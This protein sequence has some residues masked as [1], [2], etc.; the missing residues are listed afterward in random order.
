MDFDI[1]NVDLNRAGRLRIEW[2]DRQMKV[3]QA[4][5]ERFAAEQ[6]LAGE[7]IGC[8]LHVT[9]ET[10]NLMRTLKAGGAQVA[11]C[12]SNPLSTQDEVAASI[13]ADYEVPVFARHG[14]DRDTYYQHINSV[15]DIKPTISIDDG[16]DLISTLHSE[17]QALIP[18]LKAGMEET[19]TGVIRLRAMAAD[20]ALQYPLIAVNDAATKHLFDNYYGTGQ[21]TV[22]GILRATNVLL[23]GK[24]FVVC[25]YGDCGRGVAR[26][27][28]GMGAKVI[29][30][31]VDPLR[32][33][34]AAMDG[35]QVMPIAQAAEIG[36]I[37][38]TV[39][40]DRSV[41]R[42]EHFAVMKDGA[43]LGNTGHFDVEI[44]LPDLREQSVAVRQMRH[45][46][47]EYELQDGRRLYLIGEGRLANLAAAEGHPAVV[48][49]MSFANQALCAEY[50]AQ[51]S[52]PLE[53][54]VHSVPQ[55]IDE[56]V[57]A[58][59]LQAMD[60]QIDTLTP[61]QKEYLE[62]WRVGT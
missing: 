54:E 38:I 33:L 32:A 2:A 50:V 30:C 45:S 16:A 5:R 49:D 36:D 48:M 51:R 11:L 42:A 58:L 46:L 9:S 22:D 1:T 56:R 57:A 52:E 21:S 20:G 10:A 34:Q 25:G 14:E 24:N 35:Y 13:V 26:R 59:K 44:D 39:T 12:A 55:E 23:A 28:D 47:Q 62:S 6:P 7:R 40:G 29:I 43:I 18:N 4:I 15:L 61:E 17:R 3:L 53:V 31:E 19:T 41:I 8:C 37:F 27:A 60:I